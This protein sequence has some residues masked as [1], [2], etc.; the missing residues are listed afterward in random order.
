M[1]AAAG[2]LAQ[3]IAIVTAGS[4]GPSTPAAGDAS[5][6][7][8]VD[9]IVYHDSCYL[10]RYNDIYDAPRDVL[11]QGLP[12]VE[13]VEPERHRSRGLCCGAGGGRMWME[14]QTGKRINAERTE[15]LLATGARAIATACPFCMTM[16]RDGVAAKGSEVPVYDISEVIADRLE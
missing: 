15:E 14:E 6:A 16:I 8:P 2:S 11:R 10:G 5:T 7:T 3:D 1:R 4:E 9:S 13:I 12:I